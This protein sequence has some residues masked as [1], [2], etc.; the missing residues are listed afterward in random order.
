MKILM[1]NNEFPPLGGGTGTVNMELFN[2]LQ[3]FPEYKIDLITSAIGNKKEIEQFS[4]NIRIIKYPVNNKNIHHSSNFELIKYTIKSIFGTYKYNKIEK[5]N[6]CMAWSTVPAGFT[7]FVISVLT[8]IPYIVRVGGP[9]IPGFEE[10]YKNLYKVISPLIKLVWKKAK[11]LIAKCKIEQEM[12]IKTGCKKNIQIIYNGVDTLKFKPKNKS[13]AKELT[14]I[15]PARLI[16]RKGQDILIKAIALLKEKNINFKVDLIGEGDE[17][18]N[19][20]NLCKEL[21]IQ[22]NINFIGYVTRVE[23]PEYYSNSDIFVLPSY[24][25]GMSNSML[26]AMASGISPVVTNVGGVEELITD[27]ENGF[28]FDAGNVNQL[29]DILEKLYSDRHLLL[30]TSKKTRETVEQLSWSNITDKYK[31]IFSKYSK[32]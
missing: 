2:I 18:E 32:S 8:G 21:N 30:E 19:F 23:M 10:R 16:K 27:K 22:E 26:E 20:V 9:D 14:I 17:K 29:A 28:I 31:E 12:I 15:C 11:L 1:L 4:E 13:V 24:N 25:E 6:L 7:G 3:N 5:Y